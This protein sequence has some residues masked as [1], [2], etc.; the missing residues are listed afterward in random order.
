MV[1]YYGTNFYYKNSNATIYNLFKNIAITFPILAYGPLS[2]FSSTYIYENWV[3]QFFNIF[4]SSL[5]IVL[6]GLFDVKYSEKELEENPK[7][8]SVGQENKFFNRKRLFLSFA[9][10]CF[11]GALFIYICYFG[12]EFTLLGE[13][14]M[15]YE[16]WSGMIVFNIVVLCVNIRVYM[17]ANQIS[18]ILILASIGSV[19]SYYLIFF[20]VE[21]ILYSDCKNV[22][23]HQL[24]SNTF[25]LLVFFS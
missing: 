6:F 19:L 14:F 10:T 1:L 2:I 15:A 8:Y 18:L 25:W 13:G 16:I 21:I 7:C 23:K 24:G 3:F 20:L 4:F 5:P 17:I 22:L 12:N 9:T 11:F